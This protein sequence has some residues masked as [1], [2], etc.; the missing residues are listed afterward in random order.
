ML[1]THKKKIGGRMYQNYRKEALEECIAMIKSGTMSQQYA[2]EHYKIPRRT[3]NYKMK[4]KHMQKSG[5]PT[6]FSAEE[7]ERF[8]Q[9]TLKM[10]NFGFPIDSFD[11]R[12]IVKDYLETKGR[13]VSQFKNNMPGTDWVRSFLKRHPELTNRFATNIKRVRAA[14]DEAT[15]RDYI[16]NLAKV[17]EGIPAENIWNY[18]ESNLTDNPGLKKVLTKRGT[19]YP[20]RICNTSKSSISLMYCGSAAGEILPPYVVY[21]SA[22]MW[23]TWTENGPKGSRYSNT[24]TGWFDSSTF[25]DWFKTL[26]LPKLKKTEW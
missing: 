5:K 22:H 14:I 24:S 12:H 11:L 16:N 6:V 20:E 1:R 13:T 17:I 7:E 10:S 15:L 23:S 2:S 4:E 26:M 8:V 3:L 18:D 9:C 19:K 25:T 21:K